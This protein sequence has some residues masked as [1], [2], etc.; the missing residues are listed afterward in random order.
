MSR[1]DNKRE[2]NSKKEQ[3]TGVVITQSLA[4]GHETLATLLDLVLSGIRRNTLPLLGGHHRLELAYLGPQLGDLRPGQR[5]LLC[6]LLMHGLGH[7]RGAKQGLTRSL[8]CL[9]EDLSL[10]P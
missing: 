10:R 3:L 4:L 9:L 5:L 7:L 1:H 8:L 6:G 2:P